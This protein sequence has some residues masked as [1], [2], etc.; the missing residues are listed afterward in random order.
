MS[1]SSP[2]P[3]HLTFTDFCPKFNSRPH[4]LSDYALRESCSDIDIVR[5]LQSIYSKYRGS[6]AINIRSLVTFIL[7]M[8]VSFCY[9]HI[10]LHINLIFVYHPSEGRSWFQSWCRS[11]CL[12]LL[13]VITVNFS[14]RNCITP[15]SHVLVWSTVRPIN[16]HWF[17]QL[18]LPVE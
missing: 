5:V 16:F 4:C 7:P 10:N 18:L 3:I 8:V 14:K 9:I 15:V 2:A 1:S 12:T 17:Q 11:C 13:I 6:I